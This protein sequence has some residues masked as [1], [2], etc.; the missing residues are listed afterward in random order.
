DD[1]ETRFLQDLLAEVD[2]GAL[3]PHDQRH[4][5]VDLA[6]RGH[7]ALGNDVAAHDAAEDVDQDALDVGIFEDD[8]ERRRHAFL[9]G[10]AA[11]IEEVGGR[12]TIELDDV[13]G[14][15][16][17]PRAVHHAAD[18]AVELDV[19][20]RIFAGLGLGRILLVYVAQ[21]LDIPVPEQRVVGEVQLGIEGQDVAARGD[22]QRVDLDQRAVELGERLV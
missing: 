4:V 19:V 3:K 17:E 10:A 2:V 21:V 14:G 11:D 6:R 18:L 15:H 13:H 22:D 8:L 1:L 5:Q 20:Q 12:R 9:G 7:D 16:G